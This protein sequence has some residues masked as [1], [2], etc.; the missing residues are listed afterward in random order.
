MI[1]FST[2][3]IGGKSFHYQFNLILCTEMVNLKIAYASS[4]NPT[5]IVTLSYLPTNMNGI[6]Y[7][8]RFVHV[9]KS[10]KLQILIFLKVL[11]FDLF[12]YQ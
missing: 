7:D 6:N 2:F 4:L 9:S 10:V 8:Y 5:P 11:T 3:I 12:G 1:N